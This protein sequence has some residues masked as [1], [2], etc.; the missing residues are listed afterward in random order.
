MLG[1]LDSGN[2]GNFYVP[3]MIFSRYNAIESDKIF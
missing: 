1:G 2:V 3:L